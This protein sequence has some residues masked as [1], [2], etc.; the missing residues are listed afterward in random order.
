[1]SIRH[2][3]LKQLRALAET[4]RHGTVTEAAA[5]L[6]VT[7]PAISLQLKLLEEMAG[8]PL[9]FK[10]KLGFKATEAG[11]IIVDSAHRIEALLR[12]S[13]EAIVELQGG[14]RGT[15]HVGVVSTA[16]YFAPKALAAFRHTHPNIELKLTVGNREE[17]VAALE[18]YELDFA[19][20]GR[21]PQHF[22]VE[23]EKIAPHPHIIV[24]P[25]DHPLTNKRKVPLEALSKETFLLREAGSGTRGLTDQFIARIG[26]PPTIGM[27]ISSNETIKQAVMAGLGIAL[28]SAHT[29]ALELKGRRLGIIKAEG[30]PIVRAWYVVR[31]KDRQMLP[32]TKHLWTYFA[33][34]VKKLLP[35]N[36]TK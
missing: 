12:D 20:M 4:A 13:E 22:E 10:G 28:I 11:T 7:P 1:M 34:E 2:A 27:E 6:N 35:D 15:V 16:K 3:T 25:P 26:K 24:A 31:R 5:A 9:L 17:T 30:L 19:V 18:N 36:P 29:V 23:Q 21:P 14:S 32:A 33:T 8:I